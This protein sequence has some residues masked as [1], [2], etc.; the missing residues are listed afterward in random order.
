LPQYYNQFLHP[1]C[2]Q[3]SQVHYSSFADNPSHV[4][5]PG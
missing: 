3:Y 2:F 4:L 1:G 5:L